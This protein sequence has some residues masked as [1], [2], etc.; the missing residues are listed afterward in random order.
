GEITS[1]RSAQR[2]RI[3]KFIGLN[4][5]KSIIGCCCDLIVYD[6]YEFAH[7]IDEVSGPPLKKLLNKE[8]F[9]LGRNN[10][11]AKDEKSLCELALVAEFGP[12]INES[13]LKILEKMIETSVLD[14]M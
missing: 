11:N 6:Q 7:L 1:V 14:H 4:K 9:D 8:R 10:H 2:K 5:N 13:D 3:Y 12:I